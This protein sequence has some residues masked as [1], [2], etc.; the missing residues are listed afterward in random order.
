MCSYLYEYITNLCIYTIFKCRFTT[1]ISF[2]TERSGNI[3]DMR[4]KKKEVR[5][6]YNR[7]RVLR[8]GMGLSRQSLAN[9]V[10]VNHQT[11]G[12]LERAEHNP[13]LDLAMAISQVFDLPVEAVFSRKPFVYSS[14]DFK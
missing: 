1:D 9:K 4:R 2:T 8:T 3:V 13:S 5:P 7:I 11:I 6:L 14:D 10:D 12:A